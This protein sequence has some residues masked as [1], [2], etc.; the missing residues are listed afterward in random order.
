MSMMAKQSW[1]RDL[2]KWEAIEV[3]LH[4]SNILPGQIMEASRPLPES[5]EVV[6]L[7][8]LTPRME[9]ETASSL[10]IRK[11][12]KTR[13]I[14]P[15]FCIKFPSCEKSFSICLIVPLFPTE[16]FASLPKAAVPHYSSSHLW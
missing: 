15:T 16:N 4:P 11:D 12:H 14:F 1:R 2:L 8:S 6:P 9:K 3:G 7:Q 10:S 13:H 5:K